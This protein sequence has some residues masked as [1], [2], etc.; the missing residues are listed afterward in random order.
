LGLQKFK[1]KKKD[2]RK[3][4]FPTQPSRISPFQLTSTEK[5]SKQIIYSLYLNLFDMDFTLL[6]LCFAALL[7]IV[8]FGV[9]SHA[10]S[11]PDL[12]DMTAISNSCSDSVLLFVRVAEAFSLATSI[13]ALPLIAL[14]YFLPRFFFTKYYYH[15]SGAFIIFKCLF[16]IF[17]TAWIFLFIF[18]AGIFHYELPECLDAATYLKMYYYGTILASFIVIMSAGVGLMSLHGRMIPRDDAHL[19]LI[20]RKDPHEV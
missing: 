17:F 10:M 19:E 13:Y 7:P 9:F 5:A 6:F 20:K 14:L 11:S 1:N 2:K 3:R 8:G 15:F 18:G 4:V 16:L 12:V